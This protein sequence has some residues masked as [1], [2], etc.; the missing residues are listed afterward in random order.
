MGLTTIATAGCGCWARVTRRA[1]LRFGGDCC[2]AHDGRAGATVL[3][4]LLA[5][6]AVGD[7]AAGSV[8][9]LWAMRWYPPARPAG[10]E[11]A[12]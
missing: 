5:V 12:P 1:P 3:L 11:V 4:G 6:L 8:F 7:P 9:P 10:D 2:A